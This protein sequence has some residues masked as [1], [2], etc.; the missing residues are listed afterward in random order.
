MVIFENWYWYQY[1]ILQDIYIDIK[2]DKAIFEN[3][4]IDKDN[5]EKININKDVLKISIFSLKD[6]FQNI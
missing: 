1:S 5:L 4:Y 3:I 6:I 2:I